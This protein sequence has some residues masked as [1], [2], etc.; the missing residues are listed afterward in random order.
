LVAAPE[1]ALLAALEAAA[2][3]EERRLLAYWSLRWRRLCWGV[4][5]IP[6]PIIATAFRGVGQDRVSCVDVLQAVLCGAITRVEIRMKLPCQGPIGSSN[7][8]CLRM[9][10]N[11]E[12][13][14]VV[15]E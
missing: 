7:D 8:R 3:V 11:A 13:L 9:T 6:L 2:W 5:G 14:I 15:L 4:M 10:V 12:S 1:A